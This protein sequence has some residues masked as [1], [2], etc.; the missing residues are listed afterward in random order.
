M[1]VVTIGPS[2]RPTVVTTLITFLTPAASRNQPPQTAPPEWNGNPIPSVTVVAGSTYTLVPDQP[3]EGDYR[4]PA[5]V[6]N[7]VDAAAAPMITAA[8]EMS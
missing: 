3:Y 4:R 6:G 7:S 5:G 1:T 8:A 2:N